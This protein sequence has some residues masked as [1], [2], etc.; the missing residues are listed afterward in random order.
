MD[1]LLF[2]VNAFVFFPSRHELL[3]LYCGFRVLASLC[4]GVL[5]I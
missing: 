3:D 4:C 1:P 5:L 2:F